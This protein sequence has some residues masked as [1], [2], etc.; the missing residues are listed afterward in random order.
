MSSIFAVASRRAQGS[1]HL[2]WPYLA[3][4]RLGRVAFRSLRPKR[5][6][7]ELDL[8]APEVLAVGRPAWYRAMADK[9]GW[10]GEG[11]VRLAAVHKILVMSCTFWVVVSLRRHPGKV[12]ALVLPRC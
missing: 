9:P 1:F 10:A 4:R 7:G 2:N 12:R 6:A 8:T 5:R 11:V 3:A